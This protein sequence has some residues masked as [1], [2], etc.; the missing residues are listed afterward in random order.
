MSRLCRAEVIDPHEINVVHVINRTVRRC[1]LF[2]DDPLSGKNFDHRKDWIEELLEHFAACFGIDLLCYSILSNHYHLILRTRPDVV[3]SWDDT[4]VARRWL[5][6]CPQR[7]I[8]DNAAEPTEAE[9][10]SIRCCSVRLAEIRQRLSSVS[11]WMRLLNQRVAQ[12]ANKEE[13]ETGRFW[14]DRFR[15]IRLIDEES[16]VACA[17]YVELN[18]IR[19]GI[20]QTLEESKHTSVKRRIEAELA[21][22]RDQKRSTRQRRDAFLARLEI[23]EAVGPIG[24]VPSETGQRCSDKG[25]L[26]MATRQ[27][28]ELL[29]WTARQA[30]P[31]KRGSTPR[32]MP[33]ILK[34][35]GLEAS[36][37]SELVWSFEETF[38]HVAGRCD[39]VSGMR[40]HVTGRRFRLRPSARTLLPSLV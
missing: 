39:R 1:F 33:P 15:A 35:L 29:D 32:G 19:A 23:N 3:D 12:W 2:G 25:F 28:L 13:D 10:N 26:P 24:L 8:N 30:A 22:G 6:I 20:A 17:A 16:L 38:C 34:R 31:G 37:W 18:P 27:Y 4:E 11:W 5:M 36:T 9:L 21:I 7:K 40:S 14:Q